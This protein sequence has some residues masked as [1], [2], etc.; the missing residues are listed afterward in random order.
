MNFI[1]RDVSVVDVSGSDPTQYKEIARISSAALPTDPIALIIHRGNQLFN[2]AIGPEGTQ[3]NALRPAGRMSDFGWGSCYGCHPNGLTDGVT[4]MFG[5]GPRQTIS[6][7]ST[8][9]HPQLTQYLSPS[10]APVLPDFKQRVLNWSAVRDEVQDF[11]L[12]IRGVSGGEGLI[13]DANGAQDPC[14]FNLVLPPGSPCPPETAITSNRNNDLDAIAAYIAFGIRAPISPLRGQ[15]VSRGRALF[16]Q[17]NCQACHGG[18]NWTRSQVDFAPPPVNETIVDGQLT[19]FLSNVGTFDAARVNE[20]RGVGGTQVNEVVA[21]RGELGFN[22]SSLLSV[23]AGAPYL[24]DGS[25]QTLGQVLDNL[26]HRTACAPGK[27][28]TLSDPADREALVLFLASIDLETVPIP[29]TDCA[30]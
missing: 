25:A 22:I 18:N 9:E 15:D 6:M 23:H 8:F 17:A 16:E 2:T 27:A 1:S 30:P 29:L 5:D 4:W 28:D 24:H 11:E 14:V 26:T 10:G 12:N 20:V 19:R 13:V 21:A 7:E 3:E